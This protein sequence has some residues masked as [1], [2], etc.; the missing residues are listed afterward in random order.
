MTGGVLDM[1]ETD[2]RLFL[3]LTHTRSGEIAASFQTVVSHVTA[4]EERPFAWSDET[5]R[6][7]DALP[8]EVPARC[9]PRSLSLAPVESGADL[10]AA[11]RLG[12]TE[13][14]GGAIGAQDCDAFGRMRPEVFIGRVSDGIPGFLRGEAEVAPAGADG[15]PKVG[16]AVVEYRLLHLAWPRAGDRFE[17]RSGLAEVGERSQRVVHWMLDPATGRPW[18]S[19]EAV[20]VSLDLETRRMIPL[21]PEAQARARERLVPGLAL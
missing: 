16:G 10:A 20:A 5:R 4:R 13:L 15:A 1:G 3:M 19:A 6:A 8:V 17:I 7:A 11:R 2:A 21:T 9:A 18:G 12:L 14:S